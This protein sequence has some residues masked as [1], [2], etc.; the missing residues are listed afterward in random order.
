MGVSKIAGVIYKNSKHYAKKN[1]MKL[2]KLLSSIA[3]IL[4][5]FSCGTTKNI[6]LEEK[7]GS[8]FE[9]AIIV[10]SIPEEYQY[11]KT[12]CPNCK[13]VM[14]SLMMH[15]GKPYD[16]LEYNKPNGET[17]SYYFDISKFYG[18]GF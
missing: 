8:S 13:F 5:F 4:I 7:D 12:A 16:V 6:S 2:F 17:V 10:N 18:K 15:K 9:K 3:I 1:T 14:Q 11:V